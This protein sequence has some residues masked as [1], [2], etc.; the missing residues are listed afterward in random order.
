MQVACKEILLLEDTG[1]SDLTKITSAPQ[2][3]HFT[4]KA[5]TMLTLR[6]LNLTGGFRGVANVPHYI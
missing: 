1:R 2:S 6:L 3:R 4:I 5:G